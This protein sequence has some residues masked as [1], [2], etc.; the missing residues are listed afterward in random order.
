MLE[1][2]ARHRNAPFADKDCWAPCTRH[3]RWQSLPWTRKTLVARSH[4]AFDESQ[5]ERSYEGVLVD[6]RISFP[7]D[8]IL[9]ELLREVAYY[10]IRYLNQCE[11]VSS[12]GDSWNCGDASW[13][14]QQ[15]VTRTDFR[16]SKFIYIWVWCQHIKLYDM[17]GVPKIIRLSTR[18]ETYSKDSHRM[19]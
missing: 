18:Y 19:P 11:L 15:H 5:R 7:R 3:G 8:P 4:G 6:L 2:V 10:L 12:Q 14:V 9:W 1:H 16:N 17:L 13:R